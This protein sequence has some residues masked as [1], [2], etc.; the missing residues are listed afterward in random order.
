MNFAHFLLFA[1]GV[2]TALL[3][4][5]AKIVSGVV[6]PGQIILC[7]GIYSFLPSLI[8]YGLEGDI[9]YRLHPGVPL[10]QLIMGLG[11]LAAFWLML[12]ALN[13][14]SLLLP[15][16]LVFLMS[17]LNLI[18]RRS[19]RRDKADRYGR[20]GL[21]FVIGGG[22]MFGLPILIGSPLS[23]ANMLAVAVCL[24]CIAL[25]FVQ[26]SKHWQ[27][28]WQRVWPSSIG[29]YASVLAVFLGAAT[30]GQGWVTPT[31]AESF[32]LIWIGVL[33]GLI[34]IAI[35]HAKRLRGRKQLHFSFETGFLMMAI[36][37]EIAYFRERPAANIL[38]A[39]PFFLSALIFLSWRWRPNRGRS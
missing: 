34:Q 17:A 30:V 31:T 3:L 5:S 21:E 37:V 2:M 22:L 27:V 29:F 12:L 14:H 16:L 36:F 26:Q 32:H 10:L 24:W 6:P 33:F 20:I 35:I 15:A 11:C 13:V 4:T 25:L 19:G 38:L 9:P 8:Y 7:L 23:Q 18:A 1:A 39:L 28:R